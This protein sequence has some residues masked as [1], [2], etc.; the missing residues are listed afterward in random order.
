MGADISRVRFDALRDLS[1]VVLQ[2]GRLLLDADWNELVA[3]VERRLRAGAVDLGG[4]GP[5]SGIAGV[6]VVPRTTPEAFRIEATAG[7]ITIGRGR[8]YVDGLLAENHGIGNLTFDTLLAELV[9]EKATPYDQQPYWPDPDPLPAAG[10]HVAYMLV[11]QRELTHLEQ[12]DLV[13]PAVAVDTTARTQTIWQVRVHQPDTPGISCSTPDASI[14]GWPELIA[15]SAGRLSTG[16]VAVEAED[17]PCALPPSGGYRGPEHHSY[18]LEIHH[19]GAPGTATFKWSR[20]NGSVAFPVVEVASATQLRPASVGRDNVLRFNTGD[21]VEILDDHIELDDRPG[22]LRKVE[23]HDEDGTLTFTAPLPPGLVLTPAEAAARHLRV[24]RWDQ[25]GVIRTAAGDVVADLDDPTA[26]GAIPT[27]ATGAAIVLEHGITATLRAPGGQFRTGDHWIF[28]ARTTDTSVDPLTDAPPLGHHRHYARLAIVTFP[29]TESDCR[30]LWPP[31]AGEG[32]CGDCTECVT[33]ESHASGERT[34]QDAIDLVTPSGGTVCLSPGIYQLGTDPVRIADATSVTLRGHGL[35]S[36]LIANGAAVEIHNS[37]HVALERFSVLTSGSQPAVRLE[38]TV[39]AAASEL[40]ILV[41]SDE[42]SAAPA[43]A[44]SSLALLTRL[45]DS[46]ILAP[47]GISGGDPETAPLL[48]A[49]LEISGNLLVCRES[50]LR[51]AGSVAHLF[52]NQI[53]DNTMLGAEDVAVRLLGNVEPGASVRVERNTISGSGSGIDTGPAG[54]VIRDNDVTGRADQ[55]A[56]APEHSGITVAAGTLGASQGTVFIEGNRLHDFAGPGITVQAPVGELVIEGNSADRVA[57]GIVLEGRGL[58][59]NARVTGNLIRDVGQ[60]ADHDQASLGIQMVGTERA[61]VSEN[62]IQRLGGEDGNGGETAAIRVL[63]TRESHLCD[64]SV[65]RVAGGTERQPAVGIHV[66]GFF[67]RTLVKG[68]FARQASEEVDTHHVTPWTGLVIGPVPPEDGEAIT[69]VGDYVVINDPK[70]FFVGPNVAFATDLVAAAATV[71]GN[72]VTGGGITP[73][74]H[75]AI[76]GGEVIASDNHWQQPVEVDATCLRIRA[77]T[78]TV[79]S[80][81]V[82][83]GR[84]SIVLEMSGKRAAV[85]GNLTMG[86]TILDGAPLG[87]PWDALNVDGA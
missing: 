35:R 85:L 24:R 5:A 59:G 41:T 31:E 11:R 15:P 2:Q 74:G 23:V 70:N 8:M 76:S 50:G 17:D 82:R 16:T 25:R 22:E 52:G 33:P 63:A 83:G 46:V 36:L 51:F 39:G 64:N 19:G 60:E 34:I 29:G 32:P 40:A 86:G 28:A 30:T 49:A 37:A 53:R 62:S 68:N 21:W 58:A 10:T 80:N 1:G 79:T 45:R 4:V 48:T 78:A 54:Y 7:A 61:L 69:H 81:R 12:P 20:E 55:G 27:S 72:T 9:R 66:G 44:L 18:R 84:P 77:G 56:D 67:A 6:A 26:T 3:I 38:A 13:E 87:P 71:E 14:P 75:I 73:A 42:G 57:S 65:D 43:I 47:V